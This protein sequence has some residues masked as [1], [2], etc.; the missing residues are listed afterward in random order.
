[1]RIRKKDVGAHQKHHV[2]TSVLQ[3]SLKY[4]RGSSNTSYFEILYEGKTIGR[5]Q[6]CH[7]LLIALTDPDVPRSRTKYVPVECLP[8]R[9]I[10]EQNLPEDQR[11]H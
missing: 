7:K 10:L 5:L 6:I 8:S 11:G 3:A 9:F 2:E 4:K 1:M